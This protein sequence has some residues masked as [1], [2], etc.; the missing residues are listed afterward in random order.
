MA[1]DSTIDT[2]NHR[3]LVSL[4]GHKLLDLFKSAIAAHDLSKLQPPEKNVFDQFTPM[5]K[6]HA[7]DSPEYA[8]D[9]IEMGKGLQHH[10][11]HNRH[12]P[13]YHVIGINGMTLVDLMEMLC[14]WKA[15]NMRA[16][17]S[18]M[19]ISIAYMQK[20]F[21]FSDELCDILLNTADILEE[22]K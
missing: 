3:D 1:Y 16:N 14:D 15:A 19:N 13:E 6:I 2:N 21:K 11:Q 10:Y 4:Y 17:K 7:V 18:S 22:D 9:L 20:R 8:Q 12:H 5:L